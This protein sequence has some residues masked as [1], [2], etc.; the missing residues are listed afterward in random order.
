M[1][2]CSLSSSWISP[3]AAKNGSIAN[4]PYVLILHG[5]FGGKQNWRS[6]AARLS[7]QIGLSV[8]LLDMRNHGE[9]P[10]SS[11][12]SYPAMTADVI[13]WIKGVNGQSLHT[14]AVRVHRP[15]GPSILIGHSMGGKVAMNVAVS[16][17]SLVQKLVVIDMSMKMRNLLETPPTHADYIRCMKKIEQMKPRERS[18]VDAVLSAIETNANIRSFLMTNLIWNDPHTR[19]YL[20]FRVNLDALESFLPT[21]KDDLFEEKSNGSDTNGGDV[22]PFTNPSLFIAASKSTYFT[23]SDVPDIKKWFPCATI[24]SLPTTHWVHSEKPDDLIRTI[25]DF[26]DGQA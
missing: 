19:D 13:S 1:I 3:G 14:S 5:L 8:A 23:D 7:N 15:T 16:E 9:S 22:H 11:V 12:H 21:L 25:A 26:N 10:H 2:G 6:F 24:Q 20:K 18:L 4:I 17:P